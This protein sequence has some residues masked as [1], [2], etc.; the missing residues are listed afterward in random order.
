MPADFPEVYHFA[1]D[2]ESSVARNVH[3]E[4]YTAGGRAVT[5]AISGGQ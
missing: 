2:G 5:L 4:C 3:V 1:E